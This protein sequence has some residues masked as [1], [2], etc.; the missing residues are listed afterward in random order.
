MN[1]QSKLKEHKQLIVF[2]TLIISGISL[3]Y[4]FINPWK[5][6]LVVLIVVSIIL[7]NQEEPKKIIKTEGSPFG[8]VIE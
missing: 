2:L 4:D 3:F 8:W 6:V 7:N 5:I 1:I